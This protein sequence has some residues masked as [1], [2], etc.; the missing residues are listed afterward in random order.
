V[1]SWATPTSGAYT[2]L[3]TTSLSGTSTTISSISQA[4]K[5]LFV[6]IY[7]INVG[8]NSNITLRPN[9]TNSNWY[10]GGNRGGTDVSGNNSSIE[11]TTGTLAAS[12]SS[13]N[14]SVHL[15][16]YSSAVANKS[17]VNSSFFYSVSDGALKGLF[18]GGSSNSASAITSLQLDTQV[19]ASG[20][21]LLYGV[22]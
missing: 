18:I 5:H 19:S 17:F 4:Y 1:P 21:I 8:S 9:S 16:N 10:Y 3:S 22:N 20:T 7:G 15:Y 11:I 14:F 6:V 2:L 12:Q 13:N